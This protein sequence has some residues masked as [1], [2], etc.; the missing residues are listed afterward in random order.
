[1]CTLAGEKLDKVRLHAWS[2]LS[3][4]WS[5]DVFGASTPP[6]EGRSSPP[7]L[8]HSSGSSNSNI[9]VG[10]DMGIVAT[11][12][13]FFR[14]TSLFSYQSFQIPL[15]KGIVVSAGGGSES[16]LVASRKALSRW[17]ESLP[18]QSLQTLYDCF[19]SIL[20]ETLSNDRVLVPAL[21]TLSFLL[22][23]TR[24]ILPLTQNIP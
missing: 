4:C 18:P 9:K 21:E 2:C 3:S 10:T 6:A 7:L 19:A 23:I 14:L 11:S 5:Q 17:V 24:L 12:A 8:S 1:V 15:L 13:Y 22:D 16:T 20:R